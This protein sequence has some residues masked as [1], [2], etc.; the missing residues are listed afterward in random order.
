MTQW[1]MKSRRRPSSGIRKTG[2]RSTKK[3]AWKGSEPTETKVSEES[4]VRVVSGRGNTTKAKL[5]HAD[6]ATL[7][8][9]AGGKAEKVKILR[10]VENSANRQYARQ[11]VITK[12]AFIEVEV[13]GKKQLARVTSRPGQNGVV[14]AVP[15]SEDEL[16]EKKK[17][18]KKAEKEKKE[19][20][21]VKAKKE[22]EK[23]AESSEKE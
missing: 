5:K 12:N 22:A 15:A 21:P 9:P 17:G 20:K 4:E 10:V 13:A 8:T 14:S 1:H 6:T 23:E 3:L 19:E 16:L 11:D 7:N 2:D 18:K